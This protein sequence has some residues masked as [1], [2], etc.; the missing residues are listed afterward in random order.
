MAGLHKQRGR[1]QYDLAVASDDDDADILC[2]LSCNSC[3]PEPT[4]WPAL[5]PA[6]TP[7]APHASS[8]ALGEREHGADGS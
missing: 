5:R 8:P 4:G 3:E 6:F 2:T 1:Q 7:P